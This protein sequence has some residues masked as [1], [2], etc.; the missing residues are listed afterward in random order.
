MPEEQV[1][2]QNAE[3]QEAQGQESQENLGDFS[4]V[5]D[6]QEEQQQPQGQQQLA[7]AEGDQSPE[8]GDQQ[9]QPSLL[10]RIREEYG[11][12]ADSEQAALNQLVDH[13]G[14]ARQYI[15]T[16]QKSYSQQYEE[17]RRQNNMLIEALQA[18]RQPQQ[19]A[20]AQ[21]PVAEQSPWR[22]VKPLEVNE[23]VLRTFRDP[24]TGGWKENT[25]PQVIQEAERY[26]GE[27][28]QFYDQLA[29][30]PQEVLGPGMKQIAR[31]VISEVFGVSPEEIPRRFDPRISQQQSAIEQQWNSL[32]PIL[33]EQVPGTNQLDYNVPSPTGSRFFAAMQEADQMIRSTGREPGEH[34]AY[35]MAVWRMR[36]E[37]F[38][39]QAAPQGNGNGQP[40]QQ[41]QQQR[42]PPSPEQVR[43]DRR[44]QHMRQQRAT[45]VSTAGGTKQGGNVGQPERP[46]RK[47]NPLLGVGNEFAASL[48]GEN[49]GFNMGQ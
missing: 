41:Q 48:Y 5:F 7:G 49:P 19:Q 46:V 22:S 6:Q 2:N 24:A 44:K 29:T 9:Q 23:S 33:F 32:Q 12:E 21:Q 34:E 43:E 26:Q 39:Q 47:Q 13:Y 37:L 1:Q 17:L 35:Q 38:Q 28:G 11:I 31:E 4:G 40:V 25:P 8:S 3:A 18:G 36:D 42:Q 30:N 10:D 14:Q 27:L 16:S 20:A 15:E 45:G